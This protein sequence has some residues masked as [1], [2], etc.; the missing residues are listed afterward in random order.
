MEIEEKEQTKSQEDLYNE[1]SIYAKFTSSEDNKIMSKF[2]NADWDRKLSILSDFKD[3]RL[4]YF[5]KKII[6]QESPETLPK[7]IYNEIKREIAKQRA[8]LP[9]RKLLERAPNAIREIKPVFMLSPISLS[10][11]TKAKDNQFDVKGIIEKVV[12][13]SFSKSFELSM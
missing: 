13:L 7:E 3:E 9:Y 10:Q 8:H 1:E 12:C 2:H 5:G 4:K 11:V 6:Y